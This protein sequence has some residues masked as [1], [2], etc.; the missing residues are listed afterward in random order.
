MCSSA[1]PTVVECSA[2]IGL[3][4]CMLCTDLLCVVLDYLSAEFSTVTITKTLFLCPDAY[5]LNFC[6]LCLLSTP[7]DLATKNHQLA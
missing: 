3:T 6:P 1:G 4:P 7:E 5:G 2:A